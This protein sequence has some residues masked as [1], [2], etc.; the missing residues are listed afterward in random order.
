MPAVKLRK[1]GGSVT[2]AIPPHILEALS[3]KAGSEVDVSV[4]K[5]RVVLEQAKAAKPTGKKPT[6]AELLAECDFTIPYT[7]EEQAELDL[8]VNLKPVGREIIL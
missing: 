5:G 1:V 3:L 2:V 8:W 6:L 4:E 7:P